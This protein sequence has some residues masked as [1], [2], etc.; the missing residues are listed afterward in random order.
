MENLREDLKEVL[1]LF[2]KYEGD[3]ISVDFPNEVVRLSL[4][5]HDDNREE[6]L[7]NLVALCNKAKA[8]IVKIDLLE[9]KGIVELENGTPSSIEYD[10]TSQEWN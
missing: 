4:G 9:G 10:E 8:T 2:G 5:N 7:L 1:D 6:R 3:L